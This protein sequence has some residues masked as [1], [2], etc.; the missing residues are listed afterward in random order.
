M[1]RIPMVANRLVG[2]GL[3]P[4]LLVEYFRTFLEFL[5][6]FE[7]SSV[8]VLQALLLLMMMMM[9]MTKDQIARYRFL[10]TTWLPRC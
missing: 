9:T 7:L 3:L 2:L 6:V 5:H 10:M 4:L 1:A 8:V